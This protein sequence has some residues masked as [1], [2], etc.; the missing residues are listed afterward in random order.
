MTQDVTFNDSERTRNRNFRMT[1]HDD[2]AYVRAAKDHSDNPSDP[3]DS[4]VSKVIRMIGRGQLADLCAM[5]YLCAVCYTTNCQK[6]EHQVESARI[7]MQRAKERYDAALAAYAALREAQPQEHDAP[8]R[9]KRVAA[10]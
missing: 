5:G 10:A 3:Y 9:T 4:N 6:A 2:Q 1:V 8:K 7:V